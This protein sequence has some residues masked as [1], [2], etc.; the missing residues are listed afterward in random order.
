MLLSGLPGFVQQ[1]EDAGATFS[2]RFATWYLEPFTDDEMR[3]AL[4]Y[5]FADGYDVLGD[6]GPATVHLHRAA[7]DELIARCLGDPF[8]FQLAGSAAWDASTGPV[9]TDEDVALGW[10]QVRREVDGHLRSRLVGVSDL[11]LQALRAAAGAGDGAD[12][13]TIA[14][15]MGRSGSSQIGS[16]LQGLMARRLLA[17]DERGYRVVSR[18]LAAYL[19]AD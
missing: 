13:T 18:A 1:A 3:A 7:M 10:Q 6:D 19:R 17:R 14:R 16:T 2:R 9:I 11:Q 12:G 5:A 8:L 4:T 15:V